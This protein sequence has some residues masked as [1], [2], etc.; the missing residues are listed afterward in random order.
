M[1]TFEAHITLDATTDRAWEAVVDLESREYSDVD[2]RTLT[3]EVAE[4][5][6]QKRL[7]T[8]ATGPGFRATPLLWG[9]TV[10]RGRED[11]YLGRVR[12][13]AW[14]PC[15]TADESLNQAGHGG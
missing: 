9:R 8:V 14:Q 12:W 6:L 2:R 7:V 11:N 4:I 13:T 3:T 15:G 5:E 1:V 10:R